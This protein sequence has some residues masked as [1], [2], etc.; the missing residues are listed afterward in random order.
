MRVEE[1]SINTHVD[2]CLSVKYIQEG[3]NSSMPEVGRKRKREDGE[4]GTVEKKQ[5][6]IEEEPSGKYLSK[7]K[8]PTLPSQLVCFFF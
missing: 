7:K 1:D 5:K 3:E 6:L 4:G 2:E 8:M